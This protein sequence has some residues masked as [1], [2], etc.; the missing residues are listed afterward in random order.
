MVGK[1]PEKETAKN[2]LL[3]KLNEVR[4]EDENSTEMNLLKP[5]SLDLNGTQI[6]P[7]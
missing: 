4:P 2:K 7:L 3:N 6:A 1:S 5:F